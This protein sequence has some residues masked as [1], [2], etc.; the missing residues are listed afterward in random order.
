MIT[1]RVA[2]A[3]WLAVAAL[4]VCA[5]SARAD[6]RAARGRALLAENCGQCHALGQTGESPLA[7]A[8]P[9]RR[10]GERIDMDELMT[11]MREGL[12][13]GHRDMPMFRFNPEDRRAIRS[14]LNT[15]Q[16]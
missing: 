7:A 4:L 10:I 11:R 16:E 2:I 9:F 13:S 3:R 8:P 5:G 14:Y 12:S 6:E 1:L 15:I